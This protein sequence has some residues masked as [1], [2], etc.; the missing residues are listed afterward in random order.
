MSQDEV[1][2]DVPT[3][4][5]LGRAYTAVMDC[6]GMEGKLRTLADEKTG[7]REVECAADRVDPLMVQLDQAL[8]HAEDAVGEVAG[9]LRPGTVVS[10]VGLSELSA[11]ELGIKLARRTLARAFQSIASTA[12]Q[13]GVAE[14]GSL[15]LPRYLAEQ[16]C[17]RYWTDDTWDRLRAVIRRFPT[18]NW[19]HFYQLLRLELHRGMESV[20]TS[21]VEAYQSERQAAAPPARFHRVPV[22]LLPE[23]VRVND[24]IFGCGPLN[25][26]GDS[27]SLPADLHA[28]FNVAVAHLS[29]A[30]E[31]LGLIEGIAP[32][33][34]KQLLKS[35]PVNGPDGD[36]FRGSRAGMLVHEIRGQNGAEIVSAL[37]NQLTSANETGQRV[38]VGCVSED[39]AHAAAF[40]AA[41][42]LANEVLRGELPSICIAELEHL[43]KLICKEG[44]IAADWR[45]AGRKAP[46]EG[47]PSDEFDIGAALLGEDFIASVSGRT[48][49]AVLRAVNG[50]GS[51]PIVDV[52]ISVYGSK[53][54]K[55]LEALLK[56]K[57]RINQLL[58]A[59]NLNCELRRRGETMILSKV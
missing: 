21:H 18:Y 43:E 5:L 33:E 12:K 11:H 22:G 51:M 36:S 37:F 16:E 52:L 54:S 53:D 4:V 24:I 56:A 15:M 13:A 1:E 55:K 57:D 30:R 59:K 26:P 47:E 19:D 44:D 41:H 2:Q 17:R 38:N 29:M 8:I 58:A 28:A 23:T 32:D 14:S 42:Q 48:Q 7:L 31:L 27:G 6:L 49:R 10:V 25:S 20:I 46:A 40:A 39:N 9:L 50:Q 35:Q 34:F 3:E 45:S